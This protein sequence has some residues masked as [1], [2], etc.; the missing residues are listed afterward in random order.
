MSASYYHQLSHNQQSS[1]PQVHSNCNNLFNQSAFNNKMMFAN[2]N[3]PELMPIE[4][5][6]HFYNNNINS[7][8]MFNLGN[9]QSFEQIISRQRQVSLFNEQPLPI[10]M[11]E[12]ENIDIEQDEPITRMSLLLVR[13]HRIHG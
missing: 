11:D 8:G 9:N 1:F 10:K 7:F 6:N 4:E 2:Y 13:K 5:R 3:G 12:E